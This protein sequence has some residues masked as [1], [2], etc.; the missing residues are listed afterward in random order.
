MSNLVSV[1]LETLLVSLQDRCMDC[2]KRGQ[3]SFWTI[4]MVLQAD[5]AQ[6]VARVGPFAGSAN[7]DAT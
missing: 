5:E 2:A 6:V 4:P 3:K 7:L 1:C